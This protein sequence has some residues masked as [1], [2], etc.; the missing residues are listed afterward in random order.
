MGANPNQVEKYYLRAA[1]IRLIAEGFLD[2]KDR[3]A[4]LEYADDIE[5]LAFED[6]AQDQRAVTP[7]SRG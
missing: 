1:E 2:Q 3:Q 4:L 5:C 7:R 6:E